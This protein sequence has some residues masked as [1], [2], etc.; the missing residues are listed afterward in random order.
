MQN[1]NGW[2]IR[3]PELLT[4]TSLFYQL[5]WTN[6]I[7]LSLCHHECYWGYKDGWYQ[8]LIADIYR[9]MKSKTVV[10]S[11]CLFLLQIYVRSV[12][13]SALPCLSYISVSNHIFLLFFTVYSHVRLVTFYL[14]SFFSLLCLILFSLFFLRSY[15]LLFFK[16]N[17]GNRD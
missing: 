6:Y 1:V 11:V 12:Y 7:I 14:L 15:F 13:V 4:V 3:Y 17:Q 9:C 16:E 10:I 5:Q 2:L 8:T